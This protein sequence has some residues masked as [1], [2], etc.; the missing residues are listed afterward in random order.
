MI[1]N[2]PENMPRVTPYLLYED[3]TSTIEWLTNAFGFTE[4]MRISAPDGT[5]NHAEMTIAD[6]VIMMGQ[7]GGDYQNPEHSGRVTHQVYV[8][9]DDAD[10]HHRQ[11]K[12]SG[13]TI[14]EEPNETF[15]GDRRY[16]VEDCEGHHWYF[17]THVRDVAPEEMH[18]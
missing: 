12:A 4:R 8:Y 1:S 7:P 16:G 5:A 2:P 17:A 14:V 13:A 9:I 15:Y 18:P 6:G 11:A 10:A 3:L